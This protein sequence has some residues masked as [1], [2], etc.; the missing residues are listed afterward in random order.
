MEGGSFGLAALA[1]ALTAGND[2]GQTAFAG[3]TESTALPTDL[4]RLGII[5]AGDN[6]AG[7][8]SFSASADSSE[9]TT[10]HAPGRLDEESGTFANPVSGADYTT[11]LSD[12]PRYKSAN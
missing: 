2:T 1:D 9:M 5:L 6:V 12:A 3:R 4:S 7:Q 10:Y 11:S 8:T